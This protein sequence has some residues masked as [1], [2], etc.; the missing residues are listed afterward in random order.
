[1][2][3]H[4][5]DAVDAR[6]R[7]PAGW[8]EVMEQDPHAQVLRRAGLTYEGLSEFSVVERWS[9]ESLVG[10]V[11]ST[12]FLNRAALGQQAGAFEHDLRTQLHAC[13][14]DGVFHQDL[15]F[16]YELARKTR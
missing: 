5:M 13:C 4:W 12:S 10:F 8:E 3:E 2:F 1:M 14:P 16:A 7:V 9:V 11:Y 15:T 6:A